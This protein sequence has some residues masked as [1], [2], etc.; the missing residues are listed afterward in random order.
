M[1]ARWR[2]LRLLHRLTFAL[3]LG[4]LPL[5]AVVLSHISPRSKLVVSLAYLGALFIAGGLYTFSPCPSCGKPFAFNLGA[6]FRWHAPWAPR[7]LHCDAR[8]GDP[9]PGRDD[10]VR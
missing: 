8:I 3:W 10:H 5:V 9:I 2:R 6:R 4:W 7:C 1:D